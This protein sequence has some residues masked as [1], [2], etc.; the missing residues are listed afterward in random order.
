[1]LA[2]ITGH[3][4]RVVD[5][6][7][8]LFGFLA[9]LHIHRGGGLDVRGHGLTLVRRNVRVDI[10]QLVFEHSQTLVDEVGSGNGNLVLVADPAL[11]IYSYEC[12]EHVIGSLGR[13]VGH[14]QVYDVAVFVGQVYSECARIR[15]ACRFKRNLDDFEVYRFSL[16]ILGGRCHYQFAENGGDGVV[17][18]CGV[19]LSL[20]FLFVLFYLVN[21]DLAGFV[22]L[23]IERCR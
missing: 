17:Q 3:L 4:Q 23:K 16:F 2:D 9:L 8:L 15:P 1:M 21:G 22:D 5:F 11:V 13:L 12:V 14:C 19:R 20:E 7:N 10:P 6:D 18:R